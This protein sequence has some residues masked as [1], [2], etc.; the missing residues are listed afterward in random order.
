MTLQHVEAA[1]KR[2]T[3]AD[4]MPGITRDASIPRSEGRSMPP[5]LGTD[6]IAILEGRTFMYSDPIGDVP[7]G[8]IGGLVHA[9]TRFIS[10]W[11]FTIN[12]AHLLA[13][14]SSEVDYY[15]AAFF[16][17]NAELPGLRPN[18][19]GVRRLR[20]VGQG[21]HERIEVQHFGNDPLSVELRLAVGNDFADL[22]EIKDRV[23]DRS[24]EVTRNHAADG[25]GLTFRYRHDGFEAET[26]VRTS[27]PASRVDGDEFVWLIELPPGGT[28][29]TELTVP[30]RLGAI[31]L[32]PVH[33][34]FGEVFDHGGNDTL[35]RWAAKAPRLDTDSH[36]L[37]AVVEQTTRDLLAL[38]IRARRDGVEAVVPAAGLPWFLTLF[39]RDT[40][41]TAYQTVSFGQE[42]ARGALLALAAFQGKDMND[43]RDE[44]PGKI[45]HE[46]RQGELTS[47]HLKPHNP[48]YG[49][50][51]ATQLWLVLLSE[52]WR[53]TSDDAFVWSLRENVHAA[54]NWIDQFGDRD[55]DGYVE[56]QTR[57][58]QGLG[59]QCWRDSWNGVQFA[60]G[61][62]PTLPIATCEI[63]GYTYDAKRRIA[64]LA[65]GPLAE[66]DLASLLLAQADELRQRFN[67]DFWIDDGGGYYAIGL[68]GDKRRIDS[69][70]SNIG[71]LLWSGIVPPERA[72]LVARQ[73]M[74]EPLFSGWGV[75]TL[76]TRDKGFNPIGYH[77][78]T[79]W[80]HDNS[81]CALG[82]AQYGFRDEANRIALG[83]LDAAPFSAYRLPEAFSGYPRSVGN[84][85]VPYPTACSP[86]AW[87]SGAPLLLLRSMLGLEARGGKVTVDPALPERIGRVLVAGLEAFGTRWDVEAVGATGTVRPSGLDQ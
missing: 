7:G 54:L 35:S 39:G 49:T 83:L 24:A 44:E 82:L 26:A 46:L 25:T 68:D 13:L 55:G 2:P 20:F 56:Y 42:F 64:E 40:L 14:R 47:L 59:N 74:G 4:P 36:L 27:T 51:D 48:Y 86:Q 78:G 28:W 87:A 61:T 85:P 9:D 6:A 8:S 31:D 73:L 34:D 5:E 43:F 22:F 32:Q 57:S 3:P 70:T 80:P 53:W 71:H 58:P 65:D 33:A 23:R 16:L 30:I 15:S 1:P 72:S 77:L 66:P 37:E 29:Q 81:I 19:I 38:R 79:V 17:T 60:D 52:Y 75:R 21:L 67:E 41:I 10:R 63:Q 50:A 76:S 69:L 84:F 62:I 45:P 12:G 11:E 18:S